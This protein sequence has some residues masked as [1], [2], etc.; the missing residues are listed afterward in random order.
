M[1]RC[2]WRVGLPEFHNGVAT[3]HPDTF[4]YIYFIDPKTF[5]YASK[6]VTHV[7]PKMASDGFG[8]LG[9]P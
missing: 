7:H 4:S 5:I 2:R 1:V 6:L 8:R 3:C 9:L